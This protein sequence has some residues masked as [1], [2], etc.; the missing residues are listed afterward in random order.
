MTDDTAG[1]TCMICGKPVGD[2]PHRCEFVGVEPTE[3]AYTSQLRA[4]LRDAIAQRDELL[5]A[6]EKFPEP[7]QY[8]STL[9][10][11]PRYE[12]ELGE[13]VDAVRDWHSAVIVPVIAKAKGEGA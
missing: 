1:W 5:A 7:P 6:L 12:M 3:Y 9:Q 4:T 2:G 10:D 13:W 11:R 8:W